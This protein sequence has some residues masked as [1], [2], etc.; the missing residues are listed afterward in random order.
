MAF[1][2][3][4]PYAKLAALVIPKRYILQSPDDL[5]CEY[6]DTILRMKE[7]AIEELVKKYEPTA[8]SKKDFWLR[9]HRPPYNS[10]THLHLHVLAPRT[11]ITKWETLVV[12]GDPKRSCDVGDVINRMKNE[13][14][15]TNKL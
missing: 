2:N 9:F 6:L 1:R 11:E 10:V 3:I 12:M 14:D 15:S 13:K 4:K 5:P 8:Y 7:I